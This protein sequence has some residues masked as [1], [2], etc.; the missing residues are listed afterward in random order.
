MQRAFVIQS[1]DDVATAL[2]DLLPG[3]VALVCAAPFPQL[4]AVQAVQKGHKLALRDLAVGAPL[5]KYGAIIGTVTAA[6]PMGGLVHSH[7]LRGNHAADPDDGG[8]SAPTHELE[9]KV[10]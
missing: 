1:Q 5:R 8:Q 7:N 6:I 3:P 9:Y 2:E 4:S 10:Y